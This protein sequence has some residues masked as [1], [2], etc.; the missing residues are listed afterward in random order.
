MDTEGTH[1][2]RGTR[3]GHPVP[4]PAGPPPPELPPRPVH[5]PAPGPSLGDWLRTPRAAAEPGLW[6]FGH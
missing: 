3:S 5:A 6:R 4:R 1:D 2:S